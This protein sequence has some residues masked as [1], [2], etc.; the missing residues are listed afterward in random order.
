MIGNIVVSEVDA[1]VYVVLS[2]AKQHVPYGE[3]AGVT[4]CFD[5]I[6]EVSHKLRSL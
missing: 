2:R 1:L 4:E 3:L 6:Y 5:A